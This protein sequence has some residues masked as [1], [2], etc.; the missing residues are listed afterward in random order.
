MRGLPIDDYAAPL[1][2][3]FEGSTRPAGVVTLGLL[4]GGNEIGA[5]SIPW[6]V[7]RDRV[8]NGG[9]IA[10]RVPTDFTLVAGISNWAAYGL[11]LALAAQGDDLA[12][13]E[14]WTAR[15]HGVLLQELVDRAAL[16]DGLSGQRVSSVDGLAAAE[17]LG[18]LGKMR[19]ACGLSST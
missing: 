9:A 7:I 8:A 3:L 19:S 14:S 4:D 11:S 6:E 13:A 12:E 18:H 16:V 5:G 1:W 15:G 10:C 2:T 17:Y